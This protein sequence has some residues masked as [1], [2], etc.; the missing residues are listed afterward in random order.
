MVQGI[1]LVPTSRFEGILHR[2]SWRN[3]WES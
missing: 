3:D 2:F 1:R